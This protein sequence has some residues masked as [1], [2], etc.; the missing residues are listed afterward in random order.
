VAHLKRSPRIAV[1]LETLPIFQFQDGKALPGLVSEIFAPGQVEETLQVV[2]GAWRAKDPKSRGFGMQ[3]QPPSN[4]CGQPKCVVGMK[5]RQQHRSW[6]VQADS[7]SWQVYAQRSPR[8]EQHG[9]IN[10]D[11]GVVGIGGESMPRT[12]ERDLHNG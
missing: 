8:V 12:E 5:M 1:D 3:D 10:E 4:E 9:P 7:D 6:L 11:G 2:P